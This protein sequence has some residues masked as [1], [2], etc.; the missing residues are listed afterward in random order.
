T[1]SWYFTVDSTPGKVFFG[2][3]DLGPDLI[4]LRLAHD[5]RVTYMDTE[6]RLVPVRRI[7][8]LSL[9]GSAPV[10]GRK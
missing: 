5:V 9:S 3:S 6:E 10:V 7:E 2:A 4:L 1:K 8:N